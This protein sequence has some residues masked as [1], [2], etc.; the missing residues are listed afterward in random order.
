MRRYIRLCSLAN[1]TIKHFIFWVFGI[2][3]TFC[4]LH[5]FGQHYILSKIITNHNQKIKDC[6]GNKKIIESDEVFSD[7]RGL[8]FDN[9][10]LLQIQDKNLKNAKRQ[11]EIQKEQIN[12]I[13]QTIHNRNVY[14][15]SL[16]NL[17]VIL[18]FSIPFI[19]IPLFI[20]GWL[21]KKK[22]KKVT[23]HE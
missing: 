11:V 10:V 5:S 19:V 16:P 22:K 7:K 12:C 23:L 6:L 20:Y 21:Q 14:S 1:N 4:I 2:I 18:F 9:N 13:L 17:M 8:G 3:I 15:Q